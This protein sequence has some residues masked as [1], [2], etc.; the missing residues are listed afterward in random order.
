MFVRRGDDYKNHIRC[1]SEDQKYG[2]RDFQA[3]ANKGDEK[4]QQWIQV[5][6]AERVSVSEGSG[7]LTRVSFSPEDPGGHRAARR[8]A[9]TPAGAAAGQRLRQRSPQESQVP[10]EGLR[11]V[12]SF[13]CPTGGRSRLLPS[14]AELDQEQ[15]EDPQSGFTGTGLGDFLDDGRQ[16]KSSSSSSGSHFTPEINKCVVTFWFCLMFQHSNRQTADEHKPDPSD[17]NNGS[18]TSE[19]KRGEPK[20][21]KNKRKISDEQNGKQSRKKRKR[22]ERRKEE[23]SDGKDHVRV[24]RSPTP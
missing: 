17:L 1:I 5:S 22:E 6:G 9:Q 20:N 12:M 10:G 11:R 7:T 18:E 15:P 3:K 16:R 13:L 23:V 24:R 14:P 4:Q 8:P 2:G 19:E 21:G